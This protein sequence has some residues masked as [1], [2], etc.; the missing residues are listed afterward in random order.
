M[1]AGVKQSQMAE[2]VKCEIKTKARR[3]RGEP[4]FQGSRDFTVTPPNTLRV[5]ALD[6]PPRGVSEAAPDYHTN[7]TGVSCQDSDIWPPQE[8]EQEHESHDSHKRLAFEGSDVVLSLFYLEKVLPF[9]FPFYNPSLLQG[10]KAWILEMIMK[11][12]AIRQAILCQS[13]Y[14][15]VACGEVLGDSTWESVL[16]QAES[17]FYTLR[18]SLR[19]IE[20]LN[21]R[22]NLGCAV[23]V[24]ASILQVHRFEIAILSF[25]NWQSHLSA[26]VELFD[27]LINGVSDFNAIMD[28]LGPP[29]VL[30]LQNAHLPTAEQAAFRFSSAL[31]IFDD[32]IASTVLQ[33][34]PRLFKHH[35]SLL[36]CANEDGELPVNMEAVFGIQNWVML[37]IGEIAALDAWKLECK[38]ARNFDVLALAYRATIIKESLTVELTKLEHSQVSDRVGSLN[39]FTPSSLDTTHRS[40]TTRIWAHAALLYLSIVTSG[41]QPTNDDVRYHVSRVIALSYQVCP[42]ALLRTIVWPLCVA[43]CLAEPD[44]EVAFRKMLRGLEP[45]K[46]FG[47][48][49]KALEIMEEVWDSRSKRDIATRDFATFFRI[50][51]NLVLLV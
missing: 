32:V 29:A 38:R 15:S 36:C 12:P 42:P 21:F 9:L 41:W 48:I 35:S 49:Q 20:N 17:T 2:Q 14:F 16:K 37:L 26:V 45:L 47:K 25:E 13:Q 43:G 18:E 7:T 6:E 1:D 46:L 5:N 40:L 8:L 50:S 27:Q 23:R 44:Q 30:A 34:Q 11:R 28:R 3:R 33:T 10:G 24:I 19:M 31:V 22:E 51:E 39:T 4:V